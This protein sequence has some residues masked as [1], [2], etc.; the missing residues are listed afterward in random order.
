MLQ[1]LQ[2]FVPCLSLIFYY[3]L[4]LINTD[5]FSSMYISALFMNLSSFGNFP[6]CIYHPNTYP[7]VTL[8]FS[9]SSII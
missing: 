1:I 9:L 2:I 6:H 5:H 3:L 4:T 7:E 8:P